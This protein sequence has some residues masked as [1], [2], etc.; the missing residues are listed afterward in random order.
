MDKHSYQSHMLILDCPFCGSDNVVV[1]EIDKDIIAICC[2]ECQVIGP[3]TDG[4][5]SLALAIEKWNK[6]ARWPKTLPAT[7]RWAKELEA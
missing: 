3:H 5:H 6:A 7:P 4:T 2:E 1:D